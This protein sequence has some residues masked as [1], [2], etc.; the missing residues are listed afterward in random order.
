MN[1]SGPELDKF[2]GEMGDPRSKHPHTRTVWGE[3]AYQ[4]YGLGGYEYLNETVGYIKNGSIR[5]QQGRSCSGSFLREVSK[6]PLIPGFRLD[7]SL[8]SP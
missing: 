6:N 5:Q 3:I 2:D 7:T 8:H 1:L 4:L